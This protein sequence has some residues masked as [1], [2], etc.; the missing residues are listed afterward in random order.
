MLWTDDYRP[1]GPALA[2]L[3]LLPALTSGMAPISAQVA[4]PPVESILANLAALS[5]KRPV[6]RSSGRKKVISTKNGSSIPNRRKALRQTIMQ[7]E[8]S[9]LTGAWWLPRKI[10]T[11]AERLMTLAA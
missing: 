4:I 1:H 5:E 8:F 6:G 7:N 9:T 3:F 11:L 10:I 2:I